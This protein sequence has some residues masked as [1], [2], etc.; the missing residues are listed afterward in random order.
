MNK[1]HIENHTA[2][3]TLLKCP[4]GIDGLDAVTGGGLPK[5]RPTLLCGSAGCGKTLF[6]VEFLV[7]GALKFD[8]PGVLVTFEESPEEITKNVTSLGFNLNELVAQKKLVLDHIYIERS[9]IEEIGDFDLDGLFIRLA[10]AIDSIG[11]KRVALDTLE[12][13]F[14]SFDN[15]AILRA[16]LRRLFRWLKDKGV[17]VIITGERG[18]NGMLTRQGLEEYVSD[19]VIVLAHRTVDS[20]STRHLQVIKYRG[21]AHGTNEY[22]FL[23]DETGISVLPITSSGLD[24]TISNE[25]IS[26]GIPSL[27]DMLEGKGFYRGSSVL[28][29]GTAGTGKTSIASSFASSVCQRGERCLYLAFEES[30]GQIVR[31]MRSIGL[32]LAPWIDANLLK[33][34]TTRA[35]MYGL[36]MHLVV[37]H[38]LVKSFQP[39]VVIIDPVTNFLN[40]GS[41]LEVRSMITRLLDFLKTQQIT[42]FFTSLTSAGNFEEHT[43]TN[44]SSLIDTWLLLRDIELDGERNRGMFVLKSRGMASSNQIREFLLSSKGIELKEAYLGQAGVLTGSARLVQEA[45]ERA[46]EQLREQEAIQIE[47]NLERKR[48]M[49]ENQIA[50]MRAEFEVEEAESLNL[51]KQAK[52]I[53]EQ[54]NIERNNMKISR[55]VKA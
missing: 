35:T 22:P 41:N 6:G 36:E 20:I 33:F 52:A 24:Y 21:S 26:T 45:K 49:L 25:R 29:S 15:E 2:P 46:E 9:E 8:E 38:Q 37:I 12:A 50:I 27:D 32:N 10:Y 3:E 5:G 28:I 11:A 48:Q 51:L 4:T 34:H 16:E 18:S 23:I 31:N 1:N 40:N 7:Q 44:I 47:F 17:T 19:C 54:M 39:S 55:K 13:L 42:A 53:D 14:S 43:L 30:T